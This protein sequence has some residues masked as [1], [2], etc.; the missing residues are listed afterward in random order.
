MGKLVD[1]AFCRK[2]KLMWGFVRK[3]LPPI[4]SML[5]IEEMCGFFL[6]TREC[7]MLGKKFK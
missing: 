4:N 1:T 7:V 5:I 6:L 3:K 2:E